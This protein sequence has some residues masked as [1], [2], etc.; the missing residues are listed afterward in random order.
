MTNPSSDSKPVILSTVTILPSRSDIIELHFSLSTIHVLPNEEL[1]HYNPQNPKVDALDKKMTI[2]LESMFVACALLGIARR[3]NLPP[4][5]EWSQII[6]AADTETEN[7]L[8]ALPGSMSKRGNE[9][10]V[11]FEL[12][13]VSA[14]NPKLGADVSTVLEQMKKYGT[15]PCF[16]AHQGGQE[17]EEMVCYDCLEANSREGAE[18]KQKI[19]EIYNQ[20]HEF[21]HPLGSIFEVWH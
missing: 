4:K 9:E 13:L 1:P 17:L 14:R 3:I 20:S 21:P 18:T 6:S 5:I 15:F 2:I 19:L 10:Y 7:F 11:D 12:S 8:K 16:I